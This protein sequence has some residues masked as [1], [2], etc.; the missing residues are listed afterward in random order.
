MIGMSIGEV[1]RRAEIA[2]SAIRYYEREGLLPRPL[3][4]SGQRRFDKS[5]L[6]RLEM[7]KIARDAGFTIAETRIFLTGFP[8]GT[9][10]SVRWQSMAERKLQ[11]IESAIQKSRRMKTL[12][13]SSFRCGCPEIA[14]CERAIAAKRCR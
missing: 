5:I 3:R 2:T 8:N 4:I 1:G 12:L 6:G 14:D 10:P 7:I 9:K 13:K 11:E